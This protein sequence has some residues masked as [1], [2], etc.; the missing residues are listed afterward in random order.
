MEGITDIREY[1][2]EQ[3]RTCSKQSPAIP[4]EGIALG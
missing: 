4:V 3:R 2:G 1:T